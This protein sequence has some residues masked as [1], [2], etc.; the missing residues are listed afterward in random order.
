MSG[1]SNI[2]GSVNPFKVGD[3]VTI[4]RN[5]RNYSYKP[6]GYT[7]SIEQVQGDFCL[8]KAN[9][10]TGVHHSS[11]SSYKSPCTGI[12]YYGDYKSYYDSLYG[13]VDE[14][15]NKPKSMIKKLSN[16]IKKATDV[17]TQSLLRAGLINGDLEP[18]DLGDS[19]L[20]QILWFAN[21][22]ALVARSEEI[23][24]EL[25]AEEAKK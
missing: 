5:Y 19:E 11:L 4:M 17:K 21:Y 15:K 3:T 6:V 24:A 10:D 22:D 18:T 9:F 2:P 25:A 14:I 1:I 13:N 23:I 12:T 7:F 8:E 16:F 20:K